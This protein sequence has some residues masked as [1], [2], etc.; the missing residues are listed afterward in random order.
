MVLY[1]DCYKESAELLLK[2][3]VKNMSEE[4][5]CA[6]L[7]FL[8]RYILK[9]FG[10]DEKQAFSLC[11]FGIEILRH[12]IFLVPLPQLLHDE[13][14]ADVLLDF[15]FVMDICVFEDERIDLLFACIKVDSLSK[16]V[17]LKCLGELFSGPYMCWMG[18][19]VLY[20]RLLV[21]CAKAD[22]EYAELDQ[23]SDFISK[24]QSFV[25]SQELYAYVEQNRCVFFRE[26]IKGDNELMLPLSHLNEFVALLDSS[27]VNVFGITWW[28]QVAG[29]PNAAWA[30]S[31]DT[32]EL[33]AISLPNTDRMLQELPH[34]LLEFHSNK[35][36]C[37]RAR[38]WAESG[39][40]KT[41][42][43][44]V[45]LWMKAR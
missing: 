2:K 32:P 30:V 7:R 20:Y 19:D 31:I 16:K 44:Y 8:S 12:W 14:S 35:E 29:K 37:D 23:N 5:C 39:E 13:L 43:L 10:S 3:S 28:L 24:V 40:F 4:E 27:A 18:K 25:F 1:P 42:R 22:R 45:G 21:L 38:E 33:R 36:A 11:R 15:L 26:D 9:L 34:A 41:E 6:H 17:R